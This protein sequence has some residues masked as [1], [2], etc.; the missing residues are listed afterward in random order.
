[1]ADG[2]EKQRALILLKP[3]DFLYHQPYVTLADF[4]YPFK[5]L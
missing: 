5:A 1:M 4:D 2:R 3:F